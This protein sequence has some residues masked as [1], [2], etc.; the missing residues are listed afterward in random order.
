MKRVNERKD[1]GWEWVGGDGELVESAGL[2][3]VSRPPP[4][5]CQYIC[6]SSVNEI[7]V[8]RM[9]AIIYPNHESASPFIREAFPR[10]IILIPAKKV[11]ISRHSLKCDSQEWVPDYSYN[12]EEQN[13][14]SIMQVCVA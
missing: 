3:P 7:F 1:R 4:L 2:A 9:P 11:A 10:N 5:L 12:E 8:S 14:C 6:K 13:R